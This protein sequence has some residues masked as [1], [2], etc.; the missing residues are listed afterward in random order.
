MSNKQTYT[1]F[2]TALKQLD[3]DIA[4]IQD[5]TT[6]SLLTHYTTDPH[7]RVLAMV[8]SVN[9][10]PLLFVPALEKNMAQAAEPTYT[11]I[12]Y[13]DHE[14]PWEIINSAIQKQIDLTNK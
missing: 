2:I 5:P 1:N 3:C 11:V 4:F 10:S 13:Q 14:N 7:E 6:V 9:H 8:V 12:S